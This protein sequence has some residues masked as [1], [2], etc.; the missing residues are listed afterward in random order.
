MKKKLLMTRILMIVLYLFLL[1]AG[2]MVHERELKKFEAKLRGAR[3]M[4]IR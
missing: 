1:V 3:R 4:D 2:S